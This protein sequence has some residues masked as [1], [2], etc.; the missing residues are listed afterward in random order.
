MTSVTEAVFFDTLRGEHPHGRQTHASIAPKRKGDAAGHRTDN[1]VV[2]TSRCPK[3]GYCRK[4]GC[5]QPRY[6]PKV[7]RFAIGPSSRAPPILKFDTVNRYAAQD[8]RCGD[9][10]HSHN[11]KFRCGS[12][13]TMASPAIIPQPTCCRPQ[14]AHKFMG[15][16][17]RMAG[18]ARA[19]TSGLF[20]T[21]NC[22]A[23]AARQNRQLLRRNERMEHGEC[24]RRDPFHPTIGCGMELTGPSRGPCCAARYAGQ[25]NFVIPT[26]GPSVL[27]LGASATIWSAILRRRG[28]G[29]GKM[30]R[31]DH[32]AARRRHGPRGL[33]R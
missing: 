6:R 16:G 30:L 28:S 14:S 22:S 5:M 29:E 2:A 17:V 9:W 15:I 20:V 4:T 10:L 7:T 19:T 18:W 24:R 3:G 23:T 8:I 31:T 11:I 21:V 32:H 1:V 27:S 26:C 33:R 13:K 12:T 25:Y